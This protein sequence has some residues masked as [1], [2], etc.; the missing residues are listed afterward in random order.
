MAS[1][2]AAFDVV[3]DN[4]DGTRT[5]VASHAVTVYDVTNSA[6]LADTATD[7]NGHVAADSVSPAA[8]TTL[9]FSVILT[10]GQVGYSEAVTS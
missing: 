3:I 8:G 9:R 1:S 5:A 2:Y 7:V 6:A 10:N 4:G